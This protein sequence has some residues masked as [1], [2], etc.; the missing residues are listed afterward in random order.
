M[1]RVGTADGVGS[2]TG[3]DTGDPVGHI[4][5]NMGDQSGAFVAEFIEEHVQSSLGAAGSGP[6][7]TAGVMVNNNNQVTVSP[8]V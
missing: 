7:K 3:D 8:L 1:E 4:S 5:R 6:D 2:T